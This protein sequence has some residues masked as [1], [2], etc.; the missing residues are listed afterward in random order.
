ML[1]QGL[2]QGAILLFPRQRDKINFINKRKV[3]GN[4]DNGA[5]RE[6]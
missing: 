1:K 3:Q 5:K 4:V 2:K 6:I